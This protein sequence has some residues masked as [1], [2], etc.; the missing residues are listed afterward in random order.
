[1]P[2]LEWR[3]LGLV[4]Y[5]PTLHAMREYTDQRDADSPDQL[6]LLQHPRVFT[7]GQAGKPEHLLA[8]GDIPVVAADRGGQV[9]YHGPG[10]WVVYLLIDLKRRGLG[11]R[12]LVDLIEQGVVELLA[13]EGI[14]SAARPEAPGVYVGDDKIA[15]LGLRVRRGCSYHGLSLNVDMDLEPF[16]RINPC[17]YA[18]LQVTSVA[19]CLGLAPDM[20]A[21][22]RRLLQILSRRL[23]GAA[24]PATAAVR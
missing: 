1:M 11:V 6:W 14:P 18:G 12:N 13:E 9:T 4:D 23:E 21:L 22:G 20:D 17:G 7:Q 16:Q 24:K 5:E 19:R 10:Q 2:P 8:T 3:E 15:S